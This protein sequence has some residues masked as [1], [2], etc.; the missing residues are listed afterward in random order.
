MKMNKQFLIQKNKNILEQTGSNVTCTTEMECEENGF[1]T[2]E[3][4]HF[5]SLLVKPTPSSRSTVK[6]M[7]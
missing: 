1:D 3:Q 2:N 7:N 6:L 4:S 5:N